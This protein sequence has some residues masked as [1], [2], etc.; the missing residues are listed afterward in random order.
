MARK[1]TQH[2]LH[3][4]LVL[5]VCAVTQLRAV[6]SAFAADAAYAAVSPE[7]EQAPDFTL[8]SLNGKTVSLSDF[9]GRWVLL[10][11]WATWCAPCVEEMPGLNRLYRALKK[12][13]LVMLAVSLDHA[14]QKVRSFASREKLAFPV[15]HDQGKITKARY[16]LFSV[17]TTVLVG[18]NGEI[19]A[20]SAGG[21][22]WDSPEMIRY[23]RTLMAAN[24]YQRSVKAD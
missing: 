17:P 8:P 9:R 19:K 23:L 18:P 1:M 2:L 15:L 4:F 6:P 13:G 11:F 12:D 16:G 14:K 20:R 21:R 10:N 22:V 3:L 7:T 5:A 24:R